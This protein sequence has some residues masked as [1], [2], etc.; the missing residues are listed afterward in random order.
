[1]AKRIALAIGAIFVFLLFVVIFFRP[2]TSG[3]SSES[4]SQLLADAK[5]G[6]VARI[7]VRGDSL[8]ITEKDGSVRRSTK[9]FDVSIFDLLS[10][11]GV[12]ASTIQIDVKGSG[13]GVWTWLPFLIFVIVVG[14]AFAAGY[15]V[16]RASKRAAVA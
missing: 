3:S 2:T 7:E 1:M 15:F 13:L 4:L 6:R 16:G 9:E 5:A 8:R 14:G 11:N 10:Q 12:D